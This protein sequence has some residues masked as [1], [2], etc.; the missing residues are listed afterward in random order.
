[1]SASSIIFE[2]IKLPVN[3]FEIHLLEWIQ[4]LSVDESLESYVN[5]FS[6]LIQHPSPVFI[7][8]S[9]GGIIAQE[10]ATKFKNSKVILIS[11]IQHQNEIPAF[12][13]FVRKTKLYYS[14]P[15][16]LINTI[17]KLCYC[18]GTK[19]IKRTLGYYRKYLP[20][21][22]R[23]YTMWA[24]H[25]FLNW[26]QTNSLKCLQLHGN[27]DFMLPIKNIK[28]SHIIINGT[29]A[30]ILT[31]SSSIQAKIIQYLT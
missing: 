21:R 25:S 1:M 26:K 28:K 2:R 17:E 4:P 29:H 30:M 15:C 5:R 27:K 20:L 13:K 6:E 7:G 10:L 3:L 22:N 18:F 11:S 16:S 31:K 12:L 19:N 24:I 9:F 8:V 23:T 14:Y